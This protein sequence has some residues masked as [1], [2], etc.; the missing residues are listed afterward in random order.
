MENKI[1]NEDNT[2]HFGIK[3]TVHFELIPQGQ[4]SKLI[5]WK[6]LSSY[7]KLCVENGLIGFSTMTTLQ[8]TRCSLSQAVS[9]P[10]IE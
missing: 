9:G 4:S 1:A 3:G 2:H 6:Y 7:A 10:K 8:L 5:M